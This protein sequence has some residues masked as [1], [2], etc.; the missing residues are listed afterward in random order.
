MVALKATTLACYGPL[1]MLQVYDPEPIVCSSQT[2]S[3]YPN[4][5]VMP[6]PVPV[7]L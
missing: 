7:G 5:M 6:V 1:Q 3:W 2:L 4:T